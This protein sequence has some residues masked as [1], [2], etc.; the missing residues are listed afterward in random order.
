MSSTYT[1]KN[2]PFSRCTN[3]HSQLETFSQPCYTLLSGL[4]FVLVLHS[5]HKSVGGRSRSATSS[6]RGARR[7][8]PREARFVTLANL[9]RTVTCHGL[10]VME[11]VCHQ[12]SLRG[13]FRSRASLAAVSFSRH[14]RLAF[15]CAFLCKAA[16]VQRSGPGPG[17]R[18][19]E[20]VQHQ[21]QFLDHVLC[22]RNTIRRWRAS[23]PSRSSP[24][25]A[26]LVK[27][28]LRHTS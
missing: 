25:P 2:N 19:H 18:A 4:V 27:T 16:D 6:R 13:R 3:K 8:R 28:R 26:S 24:T 5:H 22:L 9:T 10:R 12:A 14:I 21:T 1:D 11:P 15:F 20:A 7:A 23:S 17:R